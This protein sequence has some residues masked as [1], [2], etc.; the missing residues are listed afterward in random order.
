[1]ADEEDTF[2]SSV[3]TRLSPFDPEGSGYDEATAYQIIDNSP[4]L[5]DKPPKP[6]IPIYS[7]GFPSFEG[8]A[9]EGDFQGWV[10]HPEEN[11]WL[12]HK[13]S[14]HPVT[15]RLLK[16]IKHPSINRTFEEEEKLGNEIVK[17]KDGYYYSQPKKK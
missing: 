3:D 4:P 6:R 13:S 17:R 11:D 14:F 2:L 15:G 12:P 5:I 1:M 9:R 10:W 7:K 8:V 16:G